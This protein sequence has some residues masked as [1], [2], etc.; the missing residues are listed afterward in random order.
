MRE[1]QVISTELAPAYSRY[2]QEFHEGDEFR[3]FRR[4]TSFS[5]T[6]MIEPPIADITRQKKG[7]MHFV[8]L[9]K[10]YAIGMVCKN[11]FED[12]KIRNLRQVIGVQANKQ[13]RCGL[14]RHALKRRAPE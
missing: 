13:K 1:Q 4:E 7:V 2:V 12:R 6:A 9:P 3:M 10:F 14:R 8:P 11:F 5:E